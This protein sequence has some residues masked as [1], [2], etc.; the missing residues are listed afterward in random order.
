MRLSLNEMHHINFDWYSPIN[1]STHT[2]REVRDWCKK[3]KINIL[4]ITVDKA[5]ISTI[6]KK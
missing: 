6:A 4:D 2:E 5:G 3:L 1:A